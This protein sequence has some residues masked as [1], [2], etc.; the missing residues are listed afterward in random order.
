MIGTLASLPLPDGSPDPPESPLYT[1]PLQDVLLEAHG[2]EVPVIPFAGR[3]WIRISAQVYNEREEY[4]C[5]ARVLAE[6]G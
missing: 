3:L 5:L 2:I 1:D 4:R 6:G